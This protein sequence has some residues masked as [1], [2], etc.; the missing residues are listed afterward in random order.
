L[1]LDSHTSL[2]MMSRGLHDVG[3]STTS[4]GVDPVVKYR[5]PA[6]TSQT[7]GWRAKQSVEFFGVNH[8]G[9]K[10]MGPERLYGVCTMPL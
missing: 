10:N 8:A 6:T 9:I 4:Q 2:Q 3:S 7:V 1:F 5:F